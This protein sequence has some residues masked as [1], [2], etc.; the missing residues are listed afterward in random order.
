MPPPTDQRWERLV[1]PRGLYLQRDGLRWR[2][3][4]R[5]VLCG[6]LWTQWLHCVEPKLQT[7]M[8]HWPVPG[9]AVHSPQAVVHTQQIYLRIGG[10]RWRWH[11]GPFLRGYTKAHW[12]LVIS[13]ELQKH[14]A[15][16]PLSG[17]QSARC[18]SSTNHAST[19]AASTDHANTEAAST[20]T[21]AIRGAWDIRSRSA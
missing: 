3:H 2:Q 10:L 19:E 18:H 21:S 7:H 20:D 9:P 8:A 4:P 1:Q 11:Q 12:F 13:P 17:T 16:W 6:H 5:S 14:L 15:E